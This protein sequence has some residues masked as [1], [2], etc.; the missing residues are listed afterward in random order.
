MKAQQKLVYTVEEVA[1]LLSLSR[2]TA[3][4][5]VKSGIIPS[6]RVSERRIVIP[7]KLLEELL[8]ITEPNV[9]G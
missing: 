5:A 8:S 6:I 4:A 1:E 7:K 2:P 3:Y 9:S